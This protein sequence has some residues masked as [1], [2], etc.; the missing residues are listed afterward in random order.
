MGLIFQRAAAGSLSRGKR[1]FIKQCPERYPVRDREGDERRNC[2]VGRAA[3]DTGNVYWM[4][5]NRFRGRGLRQLAR[6]SKIAQTSAKLPSLF[7]DGL[8]KTLPLVNL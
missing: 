3:L 5:A 1:S 6:K 2:D 7:A 8:S 4:H